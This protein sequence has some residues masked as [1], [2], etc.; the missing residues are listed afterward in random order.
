MIELND[1]EEENQGQDGQQLLNLLQIHSIEN[2]GLK[3]LKWI[4]MK[5]ARGRTSMLRIGRNDVLNVGRL[6]EIIVD[7]LEATSYSPVLAVLL[8]FREGRDW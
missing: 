7:L 3:Q 8:R 6:H 1:G 4:L 5:Y 2:E